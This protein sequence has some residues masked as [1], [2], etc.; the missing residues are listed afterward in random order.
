MGFWTDELRPHCSLP[1]VE[2][3]QMKLLRFVGRCGSMMPAWRSE[4]YD[5]FSEPWHSAGRL[6][7]ASLAAHP[8]AGVNHLSLREALWQSE[9]LDAWD[10]PEQQHGHRNCRVAAEPR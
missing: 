2:R 8:S 9:I 7:E 6:A 4:D 3:H 5:W 1:W 10:R